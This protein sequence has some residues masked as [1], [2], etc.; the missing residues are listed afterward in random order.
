MSFGSLPG[1]WL[2]EEPDRKTSPNAALDV[3][4]RLLRETGFSG[5]DFEIPDY[6]G[7]EFQ[8]SS[9]TTADDSIEREYSVKGSMLH[10]PRLFMDKSQSRIA[11]AK[12]VDP[13][14]ELQPFHQ[15][16]RPLVWETSSTGLLSDLHFTEMPDLAESDVPDGMVEVEAKAYGLNFR[17]VLV[18]LGQLDET[19]IGHECSGIVTRLGPNTEKSGLQIGDRVVS[20]SLG[21]YA[22]IS[23]AYWTSVTKLRDNMSFE[24]AASIPTAYATAYHSLYHIARLQNGESVLVHAATGGFGQACVVLAQHV[25][26]EAFATCSSRAKRDLLMREYGIHPDRILSSRETSFSNFRPDRWISPDG[27][28]PISNAGTA[29]GNSGSLTFCVAPE[30]YRSEFL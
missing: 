27:K 21:R 23:R 14:P 2:G 12:Q 11:S 10:V 15:P 13:E 29:A 7:K 4:D 6:Q 28:R 22:S 3:W 8:A 19:F 25:G 30:L 18:A 17:D 24:D 16:G 26:A 1:W 9:K 20:L 5:V